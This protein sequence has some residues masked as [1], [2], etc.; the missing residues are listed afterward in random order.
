MRNTSLARLEH[1]PAQG[2]KIPCRT[3]LA[4]QKP[5]FTERAPVPAP[6]FFIDRR[7]IVKPPTL[8]IIEHE[9][10]FVGQQRRH[11]RGEFFLIQPEFVKFVPDHRAVGAVLVAGGLVAHSIPPLSRTLPSAG[12]AE[13]LRLNASHTFGAN[14]RDKLAERASSAF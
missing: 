6:I 12:L 4:E 11:L 9:F 3:T 7:I 1:T 5:P 14:H 2:A 8:G 13:I 10:E